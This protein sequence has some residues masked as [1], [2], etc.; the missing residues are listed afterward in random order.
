MH[1]MCNCQ[2]KKCIFLQIFLHA[3]CKVLIFKLDKMHK[4]CKIKP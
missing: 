2:H 3:V 1:S 4:M